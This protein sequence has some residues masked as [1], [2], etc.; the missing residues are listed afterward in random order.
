MTDD[1]GKFFL[2]QGDMEGQYWI[3]GIGPKDKDTD[4]YSY[5]IISDQ[6]SFTLFVLVRSVDEY[7]TKYKE[8]I[9]EK[10]KELGFTDFFGRPRPVDQ[11][12][13]EQQFLGLEA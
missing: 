5:A 8:E 7:E 9:A 1:P 12:N 2:T 3:V 4:Q 13:C 10:V 6:K 11:T